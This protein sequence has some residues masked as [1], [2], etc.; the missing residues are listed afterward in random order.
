MAKQYLPAVHQNTTAATGQSISS[1][2]VNPQTCYLISLISTSP[3]GHMCNMY[4][5]LLM[6][7]TLTKPP[8]TSEATIAVKG[9]RAHYTV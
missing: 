6:Y 3:H 5:P 1:T 4:I 7:F 2:S 8:V 9:D